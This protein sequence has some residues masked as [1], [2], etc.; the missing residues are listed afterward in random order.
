MI[1]KCFD[2]F[3]HEMDLVSRKLKLSEIADSVKI[4]KGSVFTISYK[5]LP[6][7]KLCLKWVQS[8]ITVDQK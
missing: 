4:S 5:L 6:D 3:K 7:K 2:Y 8:L 1:E